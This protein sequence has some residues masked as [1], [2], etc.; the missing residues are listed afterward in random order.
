MRHGA[1]IG[2]LVPGFVISIIDA[3]LSIQSMVGIMQ[4]KNLIGMAAAIVVGMSLTVFAV[5]SPLWASNTTSGA[6]HGVRY[7]L[8]AVDIGTSVIGA[9]WYGVMGRPLDT[10]VHF[11]EIKFQPANWLVT[12]AFIAFVLIVAWCCHMFGRAMHTIRSRNSF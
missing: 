8:L 4:P 10:T 11:A 9:I 12:L 3:F 7:T 2:W 6:M 1:A 5:L